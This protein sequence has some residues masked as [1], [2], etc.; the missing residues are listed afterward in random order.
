MGSTPRAQVLIVDDDPDVRQAL[1]ELL[2][3][4]G[5]PVT[6]VAD[7]AEALETLAASDEPELMLVDLRMPGVSGGDLLA[8]VERNQRWSKIAVLV[9]TSAPECIAAEA[10]TNAGVRV[11]SKPLDADCL[12]SEIASAVDRRRAKAAAL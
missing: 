5:Y 9:M 4:D 11:L 3:S 2:D 1:A 7:G 6:C 10:L 8:A 12:L